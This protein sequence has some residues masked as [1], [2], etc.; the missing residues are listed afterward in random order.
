MK[1]N[2]VTLAIL[3]VIYCIIAIS[4][5]NPCKAQ[6]NNTTDMSRKY[7]YTMTVVKRGFVDNI[8]AAKLALQYAVD[9]PGKDTFDLEAFSKTYDGKY[10]YCKTLLEN[11]KKYK[12]RSPNGRYAAAM[13]G[14][15]NL[16]AYKIVGTTGEVTLGLMDL[17]TNTL[18]WKV[19]IPD[20]MRMAKAFVTNDGVRIAVLGC[21]SFEMEQ[22]ERSAIIILGENGKMIW[23]NHPDGYLGES[24]V[25]SPNGESV[26]YLTRQDD[27]LKGKFGIMSNYLNLKNASQSQMDIGPLKMSTS[28][29]DVND[30]GYCIIE[31][32]GS[33][34][35]DKII[36]VNIL[37]GKKYWERIV[38]FASS[39]WI[40]NSGKY[41]F[42][43][44]D[45]GKSIIENE[46]GTIVWNGNSDFV[47]RTICSSNDE[48]TGIV[49]SDK[50]ILVET[51][52]GKVLS[53]LKGD[54]RRA[55]RN[56]SVVR[57]LG[58]DLLAVI[59]AKNKTIEYIKISK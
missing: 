23:I 24:I 42:N 34:I 32:P 1:R 31:E 19:P 22:Y 47:A 59:S 11:G 39:F 49:E 50:I 41:V 56:L 46:R 43:I 30:N 9:A 25:Q 15:Y 13:D 28:I 20:A 44:T 5:N 26:A 17:A 52:A 35:G 21:D 51:N 57:F 38:P 27:N 58:N 18:L 33:T 48:N 8:E 37:N 12:F 14:P 2:V 55:F 7:P 10:E 53:V 3:F 16:K 4:T 36:S 45:N 29:S 54:F 6:T 40:S